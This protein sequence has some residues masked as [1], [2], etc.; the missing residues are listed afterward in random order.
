MDLVKI[1][2]LY[3][4]DNQLVF[5]EEHTVTPRVVFDGDRILLVNQRIGTSSQTSPESGPSVES[6]PDFYVNPNGSQLVVFFLRNNNNEDNVLIVQKWEDDQFKILYPNPFKYET[7]YKII[8]HEIVNVPGMQLKDLDYN[9]TNFILDLRTKYRERNID[10]AF[11]TQLLANYIMN[12]PTEL[13]DE[14]SKYFTLQ[15]LGRTERPTYKS[16]Q[17][18][19]KGKD[20]EIRSKINPRPKFN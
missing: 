11:I 6:V 2:N 7:E 1:N 20:V 4:V 12:I 17:T 14:Y 8:K 9:T 16:L 15:D 3:I 18:R 5:R 10:A 19:I 13:K